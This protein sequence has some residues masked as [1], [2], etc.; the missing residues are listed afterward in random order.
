MAKRTEYK[1]C[2]DCGMFRALPGRHLCNRCERRASREA[3]RA[4]KK[5]KG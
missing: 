5:H 2:A 3:A 1:M 4:G